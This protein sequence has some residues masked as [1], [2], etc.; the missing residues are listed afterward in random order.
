MELAVQQVRV[1][2][3][4]VTYRSGGRGPTLVLLHGIGSGAASFQ[5]TIERFKDRFHVIAWNAPGY[6]G[7]TPLAQDAPMP[8]EYAERLNGFLDALGTSE[9]FL[10][11]HSLGAL[12]AGIY[13]A[14]WPLRVKSLL[15]ASAALGHARLTPE[16]RAQKLQDRLDDIAALGPAGMAEKRAPNLLVKGASPEKVEQVRRVMAELDPVGYGQAVRMLSQG[17]LPSEAPAIKAPTLVVCGAED[18]TTT[19]ATCRE[20]ADGIPHGRYLE[21]PAAAHAVYVDAPEAF[22]RALADHFKEAT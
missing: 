3:A 16:V 22:W 18:L 13:A 21:V 5:P 8:R 6:G 9:V 11:G 14:H 20:L 19:P 4:T 2:D 10:L 15:L 12:I 1:G 7:S 17:D